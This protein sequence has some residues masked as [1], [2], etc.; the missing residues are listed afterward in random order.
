M[1]RDI[2]GEISSSIGVDVNNVYPIILML[3][4]Y[5]ING[6]YVRF[7]VDNKEVKK[8]KIKKEGDKLPYYT[9]HKD[10]TIFFTGSEIVVCET[11]S[12][13]KGS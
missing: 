4:D 11:K 3:F 8:Y 12:E 1:Y 2:I 5:K 6:K 9:Y 13:I 10:A 7:Y